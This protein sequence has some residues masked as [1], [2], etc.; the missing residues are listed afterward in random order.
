MNIFTRALTFYAHQVEQGK[1][2][3]EVIKS[4]TWFVE[5]NSNLSLLASMSLVI[6]I[7]RQYEEMNNIP[8]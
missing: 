8:W 7:K 2:K 1:D 6:D 5:K 3:K 4:T